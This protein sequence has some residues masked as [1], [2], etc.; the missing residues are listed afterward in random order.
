MS[1]KYRALVLTLLTLIIISNYPTPIFTTNNN[2]SAST[3]V[4]IHTKKGIDPITAKQI[5]NSIEGVDT[6]GKY[7]PIING[8]EAKVK[9]EEIPKI[10]SRYIVDHITPNE[11]IKI[12]YNPKIVSDFINGYINPAK[13]VGADKLHELGINGSGTVLAILDTGV[14]LFHPDLDD[15]DDNPNTTDLKVLGSIS[16]AE[17]DTLP[18][19]M[20]G[21]GT[22]VAS[23][24]AGTGNKSNGLFAGIAPG[25]TI[26]SVKVVISGNLTLASWVA[27]GIEWAVSHGAD[28]ILLPFSTFGFPGDELADAI[29]YAVKHGVFVVAAA[30]DGGPN[31]LSVM[32]PGMYREAF[33][34]GAYDTNTK[35]I[36]DFS[37]RGPTMEFLAKP[38]IVAPGINIVG[39]SPASDFGF[40]SNVK[41]DASISMNGQNININA[42][43]FGK[44][45]N[46]EYIVANTTAASAAIVAGCAL[47]LLGEFQDLSPES[48]A[49]ILRMTST[50]VDEGPNM[51]GAGL[52]NVSAAYDYLVSHA[53]KTRQTRTVTPGLI[54]LGF[55]Q[56]DGNTQDTY[57]LESTY[58]TSVALIRNT[59][60]SSNIDIHLTFGMFYIKIGDNDPI[61]LFQ[62][63][64]LKEMHY[65]YMMDNTV[66]SYTR[67]VSILY[68]NGL[69]VIPMIESY[70][71]TFTTNI[72]A[73]KI[74]FS[75]INLND[76]KTENISLLSSWMFDI[77][78]DG[79]PDHIRFEDSTKTIFVYG[80]DNTGRDTYIGINSSTSYSD[81]ELGN[82]TDVITHVMNN[83]FHQGLHFDGNAGAGMKW[84]LG[85]LDARSATNISIALGIGEDKN[86]MDKSIQ[87]IWNLQPSYQ[88]RN[89]PDF[90]I[91]YPNIYRIQKGIGVYK[92]SAMVLNIGFGTSDAYAAMI[93]AKP[94]GN[95][96]TAFM[97]Y[98]TYKNM[99]Q[100]DFKILTG[101]WIP[102]NIGTFTISWIIGNNIGIPTQTTLLQSS[103]VNMDDYIIRDIF[104]IRNIPTVSVFPAKLPYAPM[105][106]KFVSNFGMYSLVLTT[107]IPLGNITASVEGDIKDWVNITLESNP[108]TVD[109]LTAQIVIFVPSIEADGLHK[110]NIT[111]TSSRGGYIKVPVE[112]NL[113]Y[114]KAMIVFDS[115]HNSGLLSS[116]N[117]SLSNITNLNDILDAYKETS[118]SIY[119]GFSDFAETFSEN[120]IS[121]IEIPQISEYNESLLTSFDGMII[122][123]PEKGF[124]KHE[125]D[126]FKNFTENGKR[127]ILMSNG[128]DD[129]N[130]TAL[131]EI[132][133][134]YNYTFY[135]TINVTNTTEILNGDLTKNIKILQIENGA[136]INGLQVNAQIT[137]DGIPVLIHLTKPRIILVGTADAF[138]NTNIKK[139]DNK[140]L[141]I[142]IA[143]N[144]LNDS[145]NVNFTITGS[146]D[147]NFEQGKDVYMV[148]YVTNH[149]GVAV[150]GLEIFVG[151]RLPNG[152]LRFFL[153]GDIG[154][155]H[156]STAFMHIFW[157]DVG[158]IHAILIIF[159]SENYTG[160]FAS[161]SFTYVSSSAPPPEET[162]SSRM[163]LVI[164][165]II[166]VFGTF[167]F[168]ILSLLISR[169]RRG[170]R[171]TIPE[172]H[173]DIINEVENKTNT[174][175]ASSKLVE[176]VTKRED[177]DILERMEI[178]G[179]LLKGLEKA[180]EEF[181]KL[182]KKL[183]A[184]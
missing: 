25:A 126:V 103:L 54:Y 167:G 171:M 4:I 59:T 109:Y 88:I 137:S 170:K 24:A 82:S 112:L 162:E 51:A 144:I 80:F 62:F 53:Y 117:I 87:E 55:T 169:K 133:K 141:L 57:L 79:E 132:A 33:T 77:Y 52:I 94:S 99:S 177:L 147:N 142:N 44:K 85:Q 134:M 1:L 72:N 56:S 105:S 11:P 121:L 65:A 158:T 21:R 115:V 20:Y 131:N 32:A 178:I 36:P 40:G 38:D 135:G 146:E 161:T 42:A 157:E 174:L 114:P 102:E 104:V 37:S 120:N 156:Y 18:I 154:R 159:P 6:V 125:L 8:F 16:F 60:E 127:L 64:A 163:A 98:F 70:N 129:T 113:E 166:G 34:V 10:A 148:A 2:N 151:F 110:G 39:A 86:S 74:T 95:T 93:V 96:G 153:V 168:L 179:D 175:I 50:D 100:Y 145:L 123:D 182:A 140:Q 143:H 118:D 47:L 107:S 180:I 15:L 76:T 48:L 63:K 5:L 75:I 164:Q 152:S 139:E 89:S 183:G 150:E 45:V 84:D 130:Q 67:S 71:T 136:Y 173:V 7:I 97:K 69:I 35:S 12:D 31:Y 43:G 149:Q 124:T 30:G 165:S 26:L 58:G 66:N 106:L 155:G 172:L 41:V 78:M 91:V 83:E 49:N 73:Y 29:E 138:D 92:S 61:S 101:E 46:D 22:Y 81:Y 108:N 68:K 160:T 128:A 122:Q 116:G 184:E 27:S 3:N 111:F 176:E 90:T 13:I 17:G 181:R 28:V 19:D 9:Q 23:I 119:V 14:N